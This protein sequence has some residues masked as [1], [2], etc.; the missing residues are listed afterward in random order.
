MRRGRWFLGASL[1]AAG[2]VAALASGVAGGPPGGLYRL[3]GLFGQVVA[4]VR[5]SYVEEVSVERLEQ[6]A[7]AALVAAGDP[8]GAWVGHG[9]FPGF[10]EVRRRAVPAFGVVL[11][12]RS[13]YPVVLQVVPGSPAE[14]AG[15]VRGELLESVAGEPLRAQPLWRAEV[16]LAEAERRGEQVTVQVIDRWLRGKRAVVLAPGAVQVASP[17]VE[18]RGKVVVVR[19]TALGEEAAP[20]LRQALS[21]LGERVGVVVDLRGVVLGDRQGAVELAAVVAGG[22]VEVPL[23]RRGGSGGSLRARG[24]NRSWKVVV[25]IDGTTARAGEVA[26]AALKRAGATL[27]GGPSYGDTGERQAVPVR[28]GTL[29]LATTWC[30]GPDGKGLIGHGLVPDEAVRMREG[31]DPVLARALEIAGAGTQRQAA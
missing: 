25:C 3:A 26:A 11:G 22:E 30:L 9:Q 28:D 10:L 5:T 8:G 27:V 21:S 18:E 16:R 31:E 17:A 6:G 12:I 15:L 24:P 4:M 7:M 2:A 14:R 13:S 19:P 20:Q 29:W 23:A 1:A